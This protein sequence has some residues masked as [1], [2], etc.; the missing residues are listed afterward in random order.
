MSRIPEIVLLLLVSL[1]SAC[2][3]PGGHGVPNDL[4]IP[5]N[6]RCT[7][8][9]DF[10]RCTRQDAPTNALT[11]RPDNTV[12]RLKE[13]TFWAQIATIA[14]YLL[15]FVRDKTVDERPLAIYRE[16][17]AVRTIEHDRAWRAR[18]D[19]TAARIT[20]P[21]RSI[22][23]RSGNWYDS[24]GQSVGRC[25]ALPRREGYALVREFLG[26]PALAGGGARP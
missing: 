2:G 21:D 20:V 14:D 6:L 19:V 4:A 16:A 25:Q 8:C 18:I 24:A 12:Y 1:L 13:K 15:Q 22:D 26:K 3:R 7:T 9:D 11:G 5:I 10:I 17:G 23:Q